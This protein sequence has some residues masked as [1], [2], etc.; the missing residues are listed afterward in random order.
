MQQLLT[1]TYDTSQRKDGKRFAQQT[2][3]WISQTHTTLARCHSTGCRRRLCLP[4]TL[5][6][7]PQNLISTSMDPITSVTK[8]GW[9]S[10]HWDMVVHKVFENRDTDSL[11]HSHSLSLQNASGTVFSGG[12]GIIMKLV[13]K[14]MRYRRSLRSGP[15]RWLR[16]WSRTR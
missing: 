7:W 3:N 15:D 9:N 8:I 14:F 6:F 11:T 16:R 1:T 10:L 5:T 2:R 4:L 12:W 13:N